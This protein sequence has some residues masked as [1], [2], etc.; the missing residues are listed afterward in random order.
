VRYVLEINNQVIWVISSGSL[1][2]RER[3]GFRL[4]FDMIPV[5]FNLQKK[6]SNISA[7]G[8]SMMSQAVNNAEPGPVVERKRSAYDPNNLSP[9]DEEA[10][11]ALKAFLD[12]IWENALRE[13]ETEA[14]LHAKSA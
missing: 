5:G 13:V 14:A 2:E 1:V 6:R 4:S 9:E 3:L 11:A 12:E 10:A 7:E 8:V